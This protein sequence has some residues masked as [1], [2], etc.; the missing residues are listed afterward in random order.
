MVLTGAC[1]LGHGVGGFTSNFI[2]SP[3]TEV[4][5]MKCPGAF[6]NAIGRTTR[7]P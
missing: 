3:D 5:V 7:T 1:P 6:Q 2:H 4:L